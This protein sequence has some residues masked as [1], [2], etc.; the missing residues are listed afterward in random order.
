[1]RIQGDDEQSLIT[2]DAMPADDI[3]AHLTVQAESGNFSARVSRIY[4][5][6]EDMEAFVEE[7]RALAEVS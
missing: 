5:L 3:A 2:L 4:V 6:R 1:M 7:L